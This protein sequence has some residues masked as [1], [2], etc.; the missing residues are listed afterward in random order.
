MLCV[1]PISKDLSRFLL[2]S[3]E[4]TKGTC[5]KAQ[6]SININLKM[7]FN[8]IGRRKNGMF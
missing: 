4:K 6:K 2:E 1:F 8:S 3:V 5:Q 7:F